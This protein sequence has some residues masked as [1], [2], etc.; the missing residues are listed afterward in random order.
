[1]ELEL[2]AGE[3]G[4][5]IVGP[6]V[7]E[8]LYILAR[9]TKATRILELGTAIGYSSLFLGWA[10]SE[11]QGKLITLESNPHLA[12]RARKNMQR[13][14]I[15]EYIH[16]INQDALPAM[17]QLQKSSIDLVFMDIDKVYYEAALEK[18]KAILRPGGMLIVDNTAFQEVEVFNQK[19]YA[20]PEIVQV[21][22]YSF[23]PLHSP[24][25]DGLCI[26]LRI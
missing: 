4:I 20:D 14:K 8:L 17:D 2:S 13:A 23:L 21:Q 19:I 16:L 15:E 11:L 9:A 6:L 12:E 24:Q 1:M 7:G 5:P 26:A 18:I 25:W 10:C 22:L 3:E